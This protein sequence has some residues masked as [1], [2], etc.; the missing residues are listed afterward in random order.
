[1]DKCFLREET[2]FT[3]EK[4]FLHGENFFLHIFVSSISQNSKEIYQYY[5]TT[6]SRKLHILPL[7]QARYL[8]LGAGPVKILP[9]GQVWR[10]SGSK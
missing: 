9:L 8:A 10:D 6:P 3:M 7:Q 4:F 2:V 1:M 5:F